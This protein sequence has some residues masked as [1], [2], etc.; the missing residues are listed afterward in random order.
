M[1]LRKAAFRVALLAFLLPYVTAFAQEPGD[2][3]PPERMEKVLE[4]RPVL[5]RAL[6]A[7]DEPA[8]YKVVAQLAEALGPYAGV[9]ESPVRHFEPIDTSSPD[10]ERLISVWEELYRGPL[11][12]QGARS[13]LAGS[14]Q[15]ELRESAYIATACIAMADAVLAKSDEY[16]KQAREELDYLLSRQ[17]S[18]GMF[19]YPA[20]PGASAPPNMRAAAER[21]RREHPESVEG[22]YLIVENQ[23][24]TGCCAYSLA[25]GYRA[26]RDKRYLDAAT[27]AGDW[28]LGVGLSTNWN[29]NAFS[30]WQLAKLYSLTGERKYLDGAVEKA[31]IGVLPGLMETGRWVDQ[32]N[33][34]QSYHW[35]M[36]RAL[37]E[38]LRVMPKDHPR[39]GD[40]KEKTFLAAKTR[41]GE[42]V[43]DGASNI[44]SALLG[45]SFVLE[46]FGPNDLWDQAANVVVNAMCAAG[47]PNAV[48]LPVYIRYRT[49]RDVTPETCE[50]GEHSQ[51]A[52]YR[53]GSRVVESLN[54][55]TDLIKRRELA[56]IMETARA[57]YEE[58]RF[59]QTGRFLT[60]IEREMA[61]YAAPVSEIRRQA[62]Q[63]LSEAQR[64]ELG[65]IAQ[66][67]RQAMI[68]KEGD[69]IRA[70][71]SQA[72]EILG[73]E[74]GKPEDGLIIRTG[75]STEPRYGRAEALE[76]WQN[77]LALCLENP[78]A[79]FDQIPQRKVT[80]RHFAWRLFSL[81]ALH[82]RTEDVEIRARLAEAIRYGADMLLT[83]Q[84][85]N[86]VFGFPYDPDSKERLRRHGA[87]I[88]EEGRARGIT[89][90]ENGWII[91]DLGDGG[92]QFDNGLCGTAIVMAYQALGDEKYLDSSRRC[93]QYVKRV[94]VV[95][96]W[97]YNAFSARFLA[98]LYGV[99]KDDEVLDVLAEKLKLGVLPG[100]MANGRYFDA[101]NAKT[102]YHLIIVESLLAASQVMPSDH[103][104]YAETVGAAKRAI[105]NVAR[106]VLEVGP[107]HLDRSL[108]VFSRYLMRFGPHDI[109]QKALGATVNTILGPVTL[110]S[111]GSGD[112]EMVAYQLGFYL[113]YLSTE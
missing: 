108:G 45:L 94:P 80:L 38:L 83:Q 42:I 69:K 46:Q 40:I 52:V 56:Q 1:S 30:V 68:A 35:I 75:F 33:A 73:D 62:T 13:D 81:A 19:P 15:M 54:T 111:I 47:K 91:E 89:M 3:P 88:V 34:K 97:N 90:V 22:G 70:I 93:M 14:N 53:R 77:R 28:A 98:Y 99:T 26:T 32:H 9:P 101:H 84:A 37:N 21:Y 96:N 31:T 78:R 112:M 24:D 57:L 2:R 27:R 113:D 29:Y 7:K 55:V 5:E 10:L 102:V 74:A 95:P 12:R 64:R 61:R 109:V 71:V 72:V 59:E 48:A 50:P 60:Y 106:E 66:E 23:F 25:E 16:I 87:R 82:K 51:E 110:E 67:L 6:A 100:M 39:H 43:R 36:V 8:V 44:E 18:S 86:G 107:N 17:H 58:G 11:G 79:Y 76:L 65:V 20:Y 92:L 103:P 41:A 49:L 4:L 105:E 63:Q 85:S 104:M